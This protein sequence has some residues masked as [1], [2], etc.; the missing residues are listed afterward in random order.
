MPTSSGKRSWCHDACIQ[1]AP[2]GCGTGRGACSEGTDAHPETAIRATPYAERL[3]LVDGCPP[4][5]YGDPRA[6][7]GMAVS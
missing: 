3:L 1:G 4:L 7:P 2:R 6:V 5:T